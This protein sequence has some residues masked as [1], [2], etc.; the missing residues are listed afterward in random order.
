MSQ[1]FTNDKTLTSRERIVSFELFNKQFELKS[2]RGVFSKSQID[3]GTRILLE[4]LVPSDLGKRVL[5]LGCGY[6][7]LGLVLAYFQ[8]EVSFVLADINERAVLLASKNARSLGL[9]NR[10]ACLHSD[11]YQ[12][13]TGTFDSIVLN[14]PIRAG[15]KVTYAM[16]EGAK[17]HLVEGGSLY[18]V[19]RKAQGAESASKYIESIFGNISLI[20]R[21][22]GYF[23]FKASNY[24]AEK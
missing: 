14:P 9:A 24:P 17:G 22:R 5:D 13:V 8:K 1:Y 20:K 11:I 15:K 23:V 2:D 19:I 10:V 4:V 21:S 12:N 3:E 18:I 7:V 6:G 16:Y